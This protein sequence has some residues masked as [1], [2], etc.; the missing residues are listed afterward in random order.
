M[1][2]I[3]L[4]AKKDLLELRRD[5][6]LYWMGGV[7]L[8]LLLTALAVSWQY[9]REVRAEFE[10]GS[11]LSYQ[12]WLGQTAKNPHRA[13][14]YGMYVYKPTPALSLIDPGIDRYVGVTV[15]LASHEKNDSKFRPAEDATGLQRFGTLSAAWVLQYVLP[16][17]IIVLGFN[18]FAG[19]REQGTLRQTLSMGMTPRQLLA[20]K[21]LALTGA[22]ALLLIPAALI[23]LLVLWLSTGSGVLADN[24]LRYGWLVLGY[25][26]YLG[27]FVFMTL[28]LSAW[29]TS[30]R[31]ALLV[32]L[33][34]WIANVVI[35]PRAAS[36]LARLWFPVP[37]TAEFN[38]AVE[39]DSDAEWKKI[40]D[41]MARKYAVAAQEDL[42]RRT[43]GEGIKAIEIARYAVLNRH[44][45]KLWDIFDR[46]QNL[47]RWGG[48][49]APLLTLQAFSMGMSGTDFAHYRD[50]AHAAERQRSLISERMND[51]LIEHAG[52]AGIDY[53]ALVAL[54]KTVPAFN[55]PIPTPA[56]ALAHNWPSLLVLGATLLLSFGL[57]LFAVRRLR[58]AME[59]M[60]ARRQSVREKRVP[61]V[62]ELF[63]PVPSSPLAIVMRQEWRLM[64]ADRTLW[65]AALLFALLLGFGLHN[66]IHQTGFQD[67][68]INTA[69]EEAS[70]RLEKSIT[71]LQD[72][73]AG[74]QPPKDY[75]KDPRHPGWAASDSGPMYAVMPSLPLAP[76][77]LGQT[78]LLSTIVPVK[79]ETKFSY[80]DET[81]I[82]NPWRLLNG[83][84]DP[85]FVIIY[86][87]PLLIFAMSYNMLSAER[88]Q[89]TL[90]MLLA[91]K[92]SLSTLLLGKVAV[93]ALVLLAL[94]VAIPVGAIIL[95]RTGTTGS[96]GDIALWA[97]LIIGYGMFWFALAA[98]VNAKGLSSAS[99]AMLLV[100]VWFVL[101]L[102]A[103]V[104]LNIVVTE[105]YPAPS[106]VE[107]IA[108]LRVAQDAA[109]LHY[110]RMETE[111]TRPAVLPPGK[112]YFPDN[113][114]GYYLK[115]A[116][117]DKTMQPVLDSF[118]TQLKNQQALV[119]R[120][121]F[122]SPVIA[123]YEAMTDI[124]GTGSKRYRQFQ[125]Q[126]DRYHAQ[127][128][129]YFLPR[130]IAKDALTAADYQA[131]PRYV[132]R[133]TDTPTHRVFLTLLELLLPVL[134]LLILGR[135][136]LR[137][138]LKV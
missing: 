135:Y 46:Q 61:A 88:E 80:L 122:V 103:P 105:I 82:E 94:A 69:V 7:V 99:N 13:D 28:A 22:L 138:Y 55:Y 35:A 23:Y 30:S 79:A 21:A 19:E 68:A 64:S 34:L 108:R 60:P 136:W 65:I 91:Q 12:S 78:D 4:I 125:E 33:S 9:Q 107:M 131:V 48:L 74:A 31:I 39:A 18:A 133:E 43:F 104:A 26:G 117:V 52:D 53:T 17:L 70:T 20:G 116:M 123:T 100:A 44:Y 24:L 90:K 81:N 76:L 84:I 11:V 8:V 86:L 112:V 40:T 73:N 54:W 111:S 114:L 120:Y 95:T 72:I 32:L 27:F 119:D 45:E 67:Q 15:W 113:F 59:S 110:R 126:V 3:L 47:Q 42:P 63:H 49:V 10:R 130:L 62:N 101:V 36:D 1:N 92:L 56:W 25:M 2:T 98:T 121:S 83:H 93:R 14:H 124:A 96:L 102:I 37:V 89:G 66:G 137:H 132:W 77:A 109:S 41:G 87:L 128:R 71:Q 97:A 115:D 58:G 75:W 106:R 6:R 5:G 134:F 50:F 85:A 129:N 51:D 127:W 57:A 29:L 118:V 38:A 16:L